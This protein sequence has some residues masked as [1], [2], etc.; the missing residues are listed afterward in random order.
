MRVFQ[1]ISQEKSHSKYEISYYR[2]N[3]EKINDQIFLSIQKTP[4]WPIF[5]ILGAKIRLSC[6]TS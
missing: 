1:P 6:T 4:F 3:S 5:S 2:T